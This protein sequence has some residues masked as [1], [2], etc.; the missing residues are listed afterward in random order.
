MS[1]KEEIKRLY[2]KEI[3]LKTKFVKL[4]KEIEENNLKISKLELLIDKRRE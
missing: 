3:D 2:R 4:L 1:Y